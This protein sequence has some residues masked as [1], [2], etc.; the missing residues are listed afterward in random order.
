[1]KIFLLL[2]SSILVLAACSGGSLGSSTSQIANPVIS[3]P[4]NSV[5]NQMAEG[6]YYVPTIPTCNREGSTGSTY[7]K[8]SF[9][10]AG[11]ELILLREY[12]AD[13]T[14]NSPQIYGSLVYTFVSYVTV[15]SHQEITFSLIDAQISISEPSVVTSY[16]ALSLFAITD[17]VV[18]NARSIIDRKKQPADLAAAFVSGSIT[19]YTA[20]RVGNSIFIDGIQYQ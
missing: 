3:D 5:F 19:E 16:N 6:H 13:S 1:M 17:W 8:D 11:G 9:A 2:V 15:N 14:C 4:T 18:G 10:S 20:R 12:H 7:F